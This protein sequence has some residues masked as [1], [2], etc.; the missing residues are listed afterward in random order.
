MTMIEGWLL[1]VHENETNTEMVAWVVDDFGVAH[2]CVLPWKP[3]I[4]V[5]ASHHS[6][7]RLE[8][9]LT[10]PELRQRFGIASLLTTHA[11]LNLETEGHVDV[12]AIALRSYQ[13]MRALAEHIEARGDF[14]RFKLYSVDAHLAQ[15]FLNDHGCAPFQRVR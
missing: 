7:D 4:H 8:H 5:H 2:G 15:R 13:H 1:D 11:R 3:T 9:W 14:H 6:L 10:Q 12:L